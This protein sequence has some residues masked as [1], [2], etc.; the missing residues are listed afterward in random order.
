VQLG[1]HF[2]GVI[3]KKITIVEK[4][5]PRKKCS[6]VSKDLSSWWKTPKRR[7]LQEETLP[8]W[9]SALKWG[10]REVQPGSTPSNFQMS[11]CHKPDHRTIE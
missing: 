2:T 9:Q 11:R 4:K 7:N 10:L 5:Q 3:V 8:Q 1:W 6:P